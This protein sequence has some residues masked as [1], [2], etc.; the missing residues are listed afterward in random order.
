M[1]NECKSNGE[2]I[3]FPNYTLLDTTVGAET[4]TVP[5]MGNIPNPDR[6]RIR[7]LRI[8]SELGI[9][10]QTKKSW[11]LRIENFNT[12]S[13]LYTLCFCGKLTNIVT[14]KS[15]VVFDQPLRGQYSITWQRSKKK[16]QPPWL[17]ICTCRVPTFC[18]MSYHSFGFWYNLNQSELY[19]NC[20][21]KN[22]HQDS[23]P[24]RERNGTQ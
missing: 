22:I 20:V 15:D 14:K 8:H 7:D 21:T 16:A 13:L 3:S 12:W 23:W 4:D 11:W 2:K 17:T 19:P 5:L 6:I 10:D 18:R 24:K 9:W 1:P